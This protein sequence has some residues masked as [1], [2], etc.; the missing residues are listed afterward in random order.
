[1]LAK[2]ADVVE[3]P[4]LQICARRADLRQSRIGENF[5]GDILDGVIR[6]ILTK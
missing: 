6:K 1:M 2:V 4:G 3:M 5:G